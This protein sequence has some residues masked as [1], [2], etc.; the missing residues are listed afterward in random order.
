MKIPCVQY[1]CNNCGKLSEIL[2]PDTGLP[3]GWKYGDGIDTHFCEKCCE[4]KNIKL[5]G[6]NNDK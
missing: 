5:E 3:K 4:N 6:D 2:D 1:I